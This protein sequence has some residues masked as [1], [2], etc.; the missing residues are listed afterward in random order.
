MQCRLYE[1]NNGKRITV[2][3]ASKLLANVMFSYKGYGLS[4][5]RALHALSRSCAVPLLCA[6]C[7]ASLSKRSLWSRSGCTLVLKQDERLYYLFHTLLLLAIR[8]PWWPAM[9]PLAQPC[10][11][12][13]AMARGQRAR[14]SPSALGASMHMASWMQGTAGEPCLLHRNP[15][16]QSC[17]I[18]GLRKHVQST[19]SAAKVGTAVCQANRSSNPDQ[20]EFKAG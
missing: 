17:Q 14:Y 15:P 9:T 20:N 1:L 2:G 7:W 6:C 16:A 11:T 12:W 18:L 19:C 3:A 10:T 4:M 13:T 8:G 5:V